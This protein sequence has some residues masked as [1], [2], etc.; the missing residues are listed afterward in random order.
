MI[1]FHL[2]KFLALLLTGFLL[3]SL[4]LIIN[5]FTVYGSVTHQLEKASKQTDGDKVRSLFIHHKTKDKFNMAILNLFKAILTLLVLTCIFCL[6]LT[7]DLGF[8]PVAN[9]AL[10]LGGVVLVGWATVTSLNIFND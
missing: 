5:H 6:I 7:T 4:S 2:W 3:F 8:G 1:K 10:Y 9:V